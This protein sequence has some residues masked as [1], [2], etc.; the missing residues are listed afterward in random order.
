[1]KHA[2]IDKHKTK[3]LIQIELTEPKLD[4]VIKTH[5][6]AI[7][8]TTDQEINFCVAKTAN[9]KNKGTNSLR[10]LIFLKISW[11]RGWGLQPLSPYVRSAPCFD[12]FEILS[13][14]T[15]GLSTAMFWGVTSSDLISQ[16]VGS[17]VHKHNTA[18]QVVEGA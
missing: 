1:M 17:F 13:V 9:T 14:V 3:H 6:T 5:K 7:K 12:K 16:F 15:G 4:A 8:H 2:V 11:E 18:Q 10:Y